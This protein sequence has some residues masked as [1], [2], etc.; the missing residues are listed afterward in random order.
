M[1]TKKQ[2]LAVIDDRIKL[3]TEQNAKYKSLMLGSEKE[4]T[5]Q[6]RIDDAKAA[7]IELE[8]LQIKIG[9]LK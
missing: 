2:I 9:E 3:L 5:F 8:A 6:R 1:N 4:E 7:I